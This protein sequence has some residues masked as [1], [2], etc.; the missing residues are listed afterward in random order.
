MTPTLETRRAQTATE[1]VVSVDHLR[2]RYGDTLAVDDVS[3]SINRG[4]IFGI[5]GPNGAGKTTTVEAIGGLRRPDG[6][7]ISVLGLDALRNRQEL[8][9]RVGIQLQASELPDKLRVGEALELFASFYRDPADPDRL[10]K[11]L[12]LEAKREDRFANLSGG[13]RQRLSIAL[14][15]IGRPELAILDELTTGLDPQSRRETWKLI[16]GIR[17]EGVTVILVTHFMEEAERLC[18][19]LALL[20]HGRVIAI[21]TPA[22]M[23]AGAAGRQRVSFRPSGVV[24]VARMRELPDVRDVVRHGDRFT[25]EGTGDLVAAVMESLVRDGV[26]PLQT[27]IEQSTL[28]DAFVALT[29]DADAVVS[30]HADPTR[31][32]SR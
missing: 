11:L 9:Q 23:A 29:A 19:R 26:V 1:V 10:L 4:E 14:A 30:E 17:D 28:D 7:A 8:R 20:H 31:E 25:V 27:R 32:E 2:V 3:L 18:D 21:D 15:L 22:A 16:E 5:L 6:G 12:G 24:D 13:Q